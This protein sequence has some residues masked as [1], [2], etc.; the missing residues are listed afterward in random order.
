M[1]TSGK[2][3]LIVGKGAVV[4]AL[5]RKLKEQGIEEIYATCK[6]F[7]NNYKF[8]DI[9][10]NNLT[11]LLKFA[12]E[13][14]IDLTI[15]VSRNV[16]KSDLVSFFESNGQHVFG[17]SK[18]I[19]N[20]FSSRINEK[21]F[22]YKIH[23]KTPK[24]GIFNK[25]QIAKDFIH[26]ATFPLIVQ[27]PDKS[28]LYNDRLI[29]TTESSAFDFFEKLSNNGEKEI[30]IEEFVYGKSAT[31]YF[32]TDGYTVVPLTS[33]YNYKF[34]KTKDRGIFTDGIGCYAPDSGISASTRESIKN[35]AENIISYF[36]KNGHTYTGILG[37]ECL[38]TPEEEFVVNSIKPFLQNHDSR[39]VLNLC[40]DNLYDIFISC[41]NGAFSDEY[42]E[43]NFSELTSVSATI[44]SSLNNNI[45]NKLDIL[46]ESID[47]INIKDK[48]N[49]TY[50]FNPGE[51]F[52]ITQTCATLTKAREALNEDIEILKSDN[53]DYCTDILKFK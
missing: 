22:L 38:Y 20:T 51:N 35:I 34:S 33:V 26:K 7:N 49:D 14:N 42:S 12:L 24:F 6:C 15:P 18:Q 36:E 39:A 50:T 27:S 16:F 31:L 45:I 25:L 4:S 29:C 17:P 41:I 43:I 48:N 53:I 52:T 9:N 8:I 10:E 5:A 3:V 44:S 1:K 13:N 37:L 28:E 30:I 21:K 46:E 23:A 11:E 32:I 19:F 2:K 47:F 40:N